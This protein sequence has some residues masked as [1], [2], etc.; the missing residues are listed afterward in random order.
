MQAATRYALLS[1]ATKAHNTYTKES[2][3]GRGIDRHFLGLRLLLRE[4]ES[5]PLFD[6]PLFGKSQE[7]I[8]STSGLSAG[9]RFFGTGFGAVYPTGYGIN[10]TCH[11]AP[12][13]SLLFTDPSLSLTDLAGDKLVK[14]G[15]ESKRSCEST[16]T[17][18]FRSNLV[19]ALREMRVAC[20]EGQPPAPSA[21]AEGAPSA[22]VIKPKL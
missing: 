9:D 18:V 13:C 12:P 8:L 7:W 20:E 17:D 15:I 3:T 1:K 6:D 14:F 10:C 4:G 19:D 5:H 2:S 16:S 11:C 22:G 21:G